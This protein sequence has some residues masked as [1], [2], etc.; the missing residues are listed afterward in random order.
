[1]TSDGS[2]TLTIVVSRLSAS[3]A[4]SSDARINGLLNRAFIGAYVRVPGPRLLDDD[5]LVDD[6]QRLACTLLPVLIENVAERVPG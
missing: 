1:V 3:A 6:S 2:A 5:E 4:S